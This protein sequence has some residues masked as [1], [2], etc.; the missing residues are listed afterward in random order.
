M[1]ECQGVQRAGDPIATQVYEISLSD[2]EGKVI[3]LDHL[4]L[5]RYR[6]IDC[7]RYVNDRALS[8]VEVNDLG[9]IQ[10]SALSYVWAG[11]KA[12][13]SSLGNGTFNV[14]GA[15]DADPISVKVLGQVCKLALQQKA[16][17]LWLDRISILQTSRDDKDWQIKRM[18]DIY[19]SSRCCIVLTAGLQRLA[20]LEQP[21]DGDWIHRSWTFQE[22]V[23]TRKALCLYASK[24]GDGHLYGNPGNFAN[25]T[26]AARYQ[27]TEAINY[28]LNYRQILVS[29]GL[30]EDAN[31]ESFIVPRDDPQHAW[32]ADSWPS[33]IETD[34]FE[35]EKGKFTLHVPKFFCLIVDKGFRS[36]SALRIC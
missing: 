19:H 7:S 9:R 4:A 12:D 1:A 17:W 2:I 3:D 32:W 24:L 28:D 33:S 18:H 21:G 5:F 6:L 14:H 20:T 23:V 36:T 10:Y 8:I 34:I 31:S 27:Q 26:P 15:G 13:S 30:G 11:L 16:P 35:L 29:H 25:R 22:A